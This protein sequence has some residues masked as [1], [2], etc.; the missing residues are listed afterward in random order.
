MVLS[1]PSP[2]R[3]CGPMD[4]LRLED[5]GDLPPAHGEDSLCRGDTLLHQAPLE[6]VEGR[7]GPGGD[8]DLR[9]KALDMVVRGLGRD[10]ELAGRFLRRI[11]GRDQP[12]DLDLTRGQS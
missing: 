1:W 5:A 9:I 10:L 8:A 12:Q 7:A 3:C 4:R 6:G 11:A 2:L